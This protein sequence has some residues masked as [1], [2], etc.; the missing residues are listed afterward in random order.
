M[1]IKKT[2]DYHVGVCSITGIVG[3]VNKL[4]FDDGKSIEV[5]EEQL[6]LINKNWY[7]IIEVKNGK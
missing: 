1:L 4:K 3:K 6:N 7:E 2:K 5:K